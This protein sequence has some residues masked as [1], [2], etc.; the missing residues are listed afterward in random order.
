M[1]ADVLGRECEQCVSDSRYVFLAVSQSNLLEHAATMASAADCPVL[2]KNCVVVVV[3]VA[4]I[5]P[6]IAIVPV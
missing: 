3:V 6:R 1:H 5:I 2:Q 4:V